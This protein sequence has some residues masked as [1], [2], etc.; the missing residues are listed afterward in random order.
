M[1]QSPSGVSGATQGG[2]GTSSVRGLPPK[3]VHTHG[4]SAEASGPSGVQ[5]KSAERAARL[6][7]FNTRSAAP[8]GLLYGTTA[9]AGTL[10]E[11]M[12]HIMMQNA[13]PAVLP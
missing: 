2:K 12:S 13:A 1:R 6:E 10:A 11:G 4:K 5:S 8:A 7:R 3:V 9:L